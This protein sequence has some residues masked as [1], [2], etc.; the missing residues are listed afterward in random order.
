MSDPNILLVDLRKMASRLLKQF[1][2]ETLPISFARKFK[3]LDDLIS[4][5]K[6]PKEWK[7]KTEAS[8]H[9]G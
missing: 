5:G 1:T 7:P 6:L 4:Q 8:K 9:G 2:V 3:Q